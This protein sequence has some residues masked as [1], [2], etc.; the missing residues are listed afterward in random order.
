[1]QKIKQDQTT[2]KGALIRF[3]LWYKTPKKTHK[4]SKKVC[5][6]LYPTNASKKRL[7]I[8][9]RGKEKLSGR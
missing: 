8:K 6:K 7:P 9:R 3:F 5:P 1:M 2:M 4:I